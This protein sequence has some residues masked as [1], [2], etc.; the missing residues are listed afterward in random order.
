MVPG[1]SPEGTFGPKFPAAAAWLCSAR[2]RPA[3]L[4]SAKSRRG[5]MFRRAKFRRDGNFAAGSFAGPNSSR[6]FPPAR[7]RW[8]ASDRQVGGSFAARSFPRRGFALRVLGAAL[9]L[10]REKNSDRLFLRRMIGFYY[11]RTSSSINSRKEKSVSSI[12]WRNEK[13]ECY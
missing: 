4:R 5:A 8:E 3:S 1:S 12:R 7:G 6:S 10:G 11:I 13:S 9:D 2:P